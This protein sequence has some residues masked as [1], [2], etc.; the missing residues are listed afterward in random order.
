[1]PGNNPPTLQPNKSGDELEHLLLNSVVEVVVTATDADG[2]Q[3]VD[4]IVPPDAPVLNLSGLT[5]VGSITI[6]T[7]T[8]NTSQE[9]EF[10]FEVSAYD[11]SNTTKVE[12]SFSVGAAPTATP[13]LTATRTAR[14]TSTFTPRP[15]ATS[16]PLP[17]TA[18]NTQ[19]PPTATNTPVRPTDTPLP[20]VA[21]NTPVPPPTAT[22]TPLPTP[23]A[24]PIPLPPAPFN[25]AA[26]IV[27]Q[28]TDEVN[29]NVSWQAIIADSFM[30]HVYKNFVWQF[31]QEVPGTDRAKSFI[32]G[33]ENNDLFKFFVV[34]MNQFG[35]SLPGESNGLLIQ[36]EPVEIPEPVK[37]V[38]VLADQISPYQLQ[39]SWVGDSNARYELHSYLNGQFVPKFSGIV[40]GASQEMTLDL[41][42]NDGGTY[43]AYVR[44]LNIVGQP[45]EFTRSNSL[46][47]TPPPEPFIANIFDDIS[48]A[49][50]VNDGVDYDPDNGRALAISWQIDAPQIPD[51]QSGIGYHVY[52]T[53]NID[54]GSFSGIYLGQ[55]SGAA[56]TVLNWAVGSSQIAPALRSSGP[57]Y[58]QYRFWVFPVRAGKP[59]LGPFQTPA[60]TLSPAITV[61]DDLSST[62]DLSNGQDVDSGEGELVVRWLLDE[63]SLFDKLG[64]PVDPSRIVDFHIYAEVNGGAPVYLGRR[65]GRPVSF[66]EWKRNFGIL[67]S[68]FRSGPQNGSSYRFATYAVTNRFYPASAGAL[69]GKRIIV[70]PL[71]TA[72]PV[73]YAKQP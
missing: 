7:L 60:V 1:M 16:T 55:T 28:G 61:T 26:E 22:N 15:T 30:V 17:P 72:G 21:T 39:V 36:E 50:E 68:A 32:L 58:G 62:L 48:L 56:Q 35:P 14:P 66:F 63:A 13:T 65:G 40:P 3:P 59:P 19:V 27:G 67:T 11:G 38:L 47:V 9:G 46:S 73:A 70:G 33:Y 53:T 24:T 51:F 52:V 69:A 20:P 43:V 34:A 25:V 37:P 18:T 23:T 64:N 12:I 2:P 31:A 54:S 4:I 10:E 41:T 45:S 29:V 71:Y 57:A 8:L 42:P 5:Q 6:R 44:G 49:A